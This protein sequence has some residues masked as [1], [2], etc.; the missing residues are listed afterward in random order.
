MKKFF[1]KPITWG[2]YFKLAGI[3][4]LIGLL[5]TA[6]SYLVLFWDYLEEW[7]VRTFCKKTWKKLMK[8]L[9]RSEEA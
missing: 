7:F 6:V 8:M 9:E 3:F 4:S 5:I 2:G 1:N